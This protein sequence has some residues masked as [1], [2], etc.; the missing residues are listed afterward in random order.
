[1]ILSEF[2]KIL[3]QHEQDI[4]NGKTSLEFL[5]EW[6]KDVLSKRPKTNAEKI[7]HTE[8]LKAQKQN[9]KIREL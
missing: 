3:Q 7:I 6:F 8:I 5:T 1:M 9:L 2:S 4:V